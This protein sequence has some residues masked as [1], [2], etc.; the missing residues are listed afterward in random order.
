MRV[1]VNKRSHV[2]LDRIRKP[3]VR[4]QWPCWLTNFSKEAYYVSPGMRR[5]ALPHGA[6]P[7]GESTVAVMQAGNRR[8][9]HASLTKPSPMSIADQGAFPFR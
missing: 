7:S 9:V 5:M 6:V 3:L 8:L 1:R 2:T 4:K